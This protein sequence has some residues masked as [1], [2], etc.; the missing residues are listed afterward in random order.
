MSFFSCWLSLQRRGIRGTEDLSAS[1]VAKKKAEEIVLQ[2]KAIKEEKI[3]AAKVKKREVA[4]EKKAAKEAVKEA[5]KGKGIGEIGNTK[6]K[7]RRR[8]LTRTLHQK[9]HRRRRKLHRRKRL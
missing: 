2:D 6:A 1:I 3:E 5:A 7:K 4:A 9:L 8:R